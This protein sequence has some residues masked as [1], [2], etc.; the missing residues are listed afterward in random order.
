MRRIALMAILGGMCQCLVPA[1]AYAWYGWFDQL[2]GAGPW[3]G[4]HVDLRIA[5]FN[6]SR[7]KAPPATA[8]QLTPNGDLPSPI[9]R[10]M[11]R[12]AFGLEAGCP[13]DREGYK[14]QSSVGVEFRLFHADADPRYATNREIRLV[15]IEPSFSRSLFRDPNWNFVDIGAA[16]GVYWFSSEGMQS[17]NGIILEP[18]RVDLHL[19]PFK[20]DVNAPITSGDI[21]LAVLQMAVFRLGVVMF[22]AGFEPNAFA[23]N[24][25][26]TARRLPSEWLFARTVFL[27]FSPLLRLRRTP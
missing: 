2:S 8:E 10:E 19:P 27:D 14:R 25:R 4:Y 15:T 18:L 17:L 21:A 3:K 22:P 26:E 23:A 7:P 12:S 1:P 13:V 16:G 11:E 20:R 9:K 6:D 24:T 5:C